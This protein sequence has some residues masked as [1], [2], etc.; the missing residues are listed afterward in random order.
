MSQKE[1]GSSPKL[2]VKRFHD[3]LFCF[4]VEIDD[5]VAAENDIHLSEQRDLRLVKQVHVHEST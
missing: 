4:E 1:I 2:V 5:H 3:T